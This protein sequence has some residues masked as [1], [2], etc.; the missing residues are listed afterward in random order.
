MILGVK[1]NKICQ[2]SFGFTLVNKL[3]S[4]LDLVVHHFVC[5]LKAW[6]DPALQWD[7]SEFGWIDEV[8]LSPSDVWVPDTVLLNKYAYYK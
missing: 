1:Y 7:K 5:F 8:S 3:R 4:N 6:Y 2:K